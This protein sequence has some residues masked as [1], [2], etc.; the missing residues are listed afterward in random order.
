MSLLVWIQCSNTQSYRVVCGRLFGV[1]TGISGALELD[2]GSAGR[3]RA[4][5]VAAAAALGFDRQRLPSARRRGRRRGDV[6]AVHHAVRHAGEVEEP[7]GRDD[8]GGRR[9]EAGDRVGVAGGG[10]RG[11]GRRGLLVGLVL[12]AH[13]LMGLQNELQ[14]LPLLLQLGDLLLQGR[15]LLFPILGFAY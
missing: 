12:A 9:V 7:R 10:G 6:G 3:F 5:H 1:F 14:L 2:K 15:V 4:R 13:G 8:L 11:G